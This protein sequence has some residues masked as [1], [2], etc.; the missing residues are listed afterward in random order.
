VNFSRDFPPGPRYNGGMSKDTPRHDDAAAAAAA[1][2]VRLRRPDRSQVVMTC[3]ALDDVLAADHPARV[4]WAVVERMDLSAFLTHVKARAGVAGRDATDPRVLAAL[5]LYAAI[6]GVGS[7]RELDR[8]CGQSDP[9]RWLCGG[10]PVNHHTLAD[11]R[12][13]HA[14]ALDGL[15]TR[16][17]ASLVDQGLVDVHRIATDGTRV[18]A[19]AGSSSF[20]R[21]GR[22]AALLARAAAH[23]AEPRGRL[24]DPAQSAGLSARRRAARVRAAR[25][26]LERLERALATMPELEARQ[27]A[28]RD[29][30][31]RDKQPRASTTDPEARVMRMP[32]GGYRARPS[33][34][35]SRSTRPAGRSSAWTCATR[36][37][38]PGWPGRCASR[39]SGG[40]VGRSPSRW[41][42]A[43]TW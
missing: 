6:D 18:R 16:A 41:W 36:A 28:S 35:S 22:L 17:I 37:T 14:D 4:V 43:G 26:R 21:R 27:R 23:V 11:F 19:C 25:G 38:T 8:L 1:G 3:A 7:A 9:Y 30:R 24:D 31:R 42:T 15:F 20:R 29:R 2:D 10:V 32:D 39:S 12:V 34:S 13:G 33:T 5:W 40:R